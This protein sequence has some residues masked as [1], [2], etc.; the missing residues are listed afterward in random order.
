MLLKSCVTARLSLFVFLLSLVVP[1]G[2]F[3]QE[4]NPK[5]GHVARTRTAEH[6]ANQ[7]AGGDRENPKAREEWFLRGRQVNGRPAPQ[8]LMKAQQQRDVLRSRA[9]KARQMRAAARVLNP[10]ATGTTT[11]GW[12]ELGPSPL[13]SVTTTG[14]DQDYGFV[15]GRVTSVAVDQSDL[16]GNTVYIGAAYGGVWKSTNAANPDVTKVI[17][18]PLTDDQPTLAVGAIAIDPADSNVLLAGTGEANSSADSYY[19]LGILRSD[20]GGNS[21]ALVSVAN[22][23]FRPFHGLAFAKIAFNTTNPNIVVAATAAASEGLTVGAE[24]PPNNVTD[25]GNPAAIATCRGLYYSLDAGQSWNQAIMVDGSNAPDN[26]SASDV[27]YNAAEQKFYAW[28]RG[29]GLY[30][31]VDGVVFSRAADQ[32]T[33]VTGAIHQPA[34]SINLNNCPSAPVNLTTCPVYRGQI[35]V[36][37]G[38]DEMYVWFV[39][40]SST[41]VD[42][43][44]FGTVDGGK[45]WTTLSVNGIENCG[46][47]EGCGT[48]QGDYNLVLMAVPAGSGTDLYAGAVNIYRCQVTANNQDCSAQPF[49]NLTHAY[50]CTPTGSF[51]K[52]HPDQHAFDFLSSNPN[53]IYF[54]NDG[55]IYRT[56]A[57][58]NVATVPTSC[59]ASGPSQ[60]FYPFDNLNGTMGSI[61]QFVWFQQHPTNQYTLLGGTQDNGSPAIDSANSGAN[62]L[63]WRSVLGGDGGW[64][65]INPNNPNEWFTENTRLDPGIQRCT[66]GTSCTDSQFAP[67][68]TAQT[69]G[70]DSAAFYMPFMLDPQNSAQMIL[71]T[72]RV[73]RVP[74]SGANPPTIALSPHFDGSGGSCPE[75]S[76]SFVSAL[77][78]GGPKTAN[79]SQVIYAGTADGRVWMTQAADTGSTSWAEVSPVQGGFQA[80]SCSTYMGC[81]YPVS[82]IALDS[83]DATG[84]TAYVTAMGFQIGHIWQTTDAG[85]SWVDISGNLPDAPADS[86]VIDPSTGTIYV[87]SDTG[88]FS[89][90]S[91]NGSNT[92]WTE[93]GPATGPGTLPNVAV[94]RVAIFSPAGQP[95]RLRASTYGRGIWEMPLPGTTAPDYELSMSNADL[96]TFPGESVTYAGSMTAFN[97]Y[98]GTVTL[99][100]NGV[101]PGTCTTSAISSGSF[102]VTASN[103]SVQDFSF[104]IQGTDGTLVRQAAVSLRVI[105]FSV[106]SPSPTSTIVVHGN[107]TSAKVSVTSLGSFDR[108][109]SADC[110]PATVP[111]GMTCS[112][113]PVGLSAGGTA[114]VTVTIATSVST[115]AGSYTPKIRFTSTLD[116]SHSV[117]HTQNVQ[118]QVTAQAS[119]VFDA[120]EYSTSKLKVGQTLSANIMLTPH[121]SYAGTVNLTCSAPG[122]GITSGCTVN[123]ANVTINPNTVSVPLT[124]TLP[125]AGGAAA[126]QQVIVSGSDGSVSNQATLSFLLTDFAIGGSLQPGNVSPGTNDSFTFQL[127][128]LGGYTGTVNLACNTASLGQTVPC[129]F[130]PPS[131]TLSAGTTT[132]VTVSVP[133]PSGTSS[134]THAIMV[135]ATDATFAQLSHSQTTGTFLVQT[136]DFSFSLESSSLSAAAGSAITPIPLTVLANGGFNGTIS[137]GVAGCPQLAT[138]TIS[139]GTTSAGQTATLTI[140]TT[141]PSL[142]SLRTDH[143]TSFAF[144]IG[145]PFGAVGLVTLR[146]KNAWMVALLLGLAAC[147]GGSGGGGS[148]STPPV[149]HPGTPAGTYTIVVTGT[150]TSPVLQHSQNFTLTVK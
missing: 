110:D 84:K 14:D 40:S 13:R 7:D 71:G 80:A 27:I 4:V 46:D 56:L 81:Q 143:G 101:I 108:T 44:I 120:S 35:A 24:E 126:T 139:P 78:A 146:R 25:C 130:D 54:G 53:T 117:T 67:V 50:G 134:G 8:L 6:D 18:T 3:A 10:L 41:P 122:S 142:S 43:G 26:G 58:Q 11:P 19:G 129:S 42:G 49:V 107:S 145:L 128:P 76:T 114:Q 141:A 100:C 21:W 48:E 2:S 91:A 12:M 23:G 93:V 37:P 133:I 85:G 99:A 125:T 102:S 149:T 31:S 148:S 87:A 111:S 98:S 131:P 69:V 94:T 96:V 61:T 119:F 47:A 88:V 52:M 1:L 17:W 70:R 121:D 109:V 15:T 64:T 45:T 33:G 20:D 83:R 89:T 60:P 68:I 106:G 95:P 75:N 9:I 140:A 104:K 28:S 65:D 73:W 39:D 51:S 138:C 74:S 118:V 115:A 66:V 57:S 123:P 79:G 135:T 5:E 82:G 137:W 127:V 150:S 144:W 92:N 103:S 124:V 36:V 72:C 97:G 62:G 116:G 63:T 113:T 147:G 32:G 29:H 16:T 105:D 55:G 30:T 136:S 38:R 59:P 22:N 77:V 86:V 34:A 132:L 112:A 90:G